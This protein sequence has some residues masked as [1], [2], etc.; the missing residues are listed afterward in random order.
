[1]V[2]IL[3]CNGHPTKSHA[4]PYTNLIENTP[5]ELKCQNK[6]SLKPDVH[7]WIDKIPST[8]LVEKTCITL[9]TSHEQLSAC[10]KSQTQVTLGNQGVFQSQWGL[11][12][13]DHSKW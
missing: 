12:P 2:L 9:L 10:N 7:T 4:T 8:S 6:W 5:V 11:E 1:M 13:K 3:P